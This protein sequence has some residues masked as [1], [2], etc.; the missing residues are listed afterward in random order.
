[1]VVGSVA[2]LAALKGQNWGESMA[3]LKDL[4]S[5]VLKGTR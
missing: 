1:M 5:V 3:E 4:Q 2:Y